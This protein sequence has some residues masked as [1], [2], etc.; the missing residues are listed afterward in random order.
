MDNDKI[1]EFVQ[2]QIRRNLTNLF[3][4][5]LLI[6]ED[7]NLTDSEYQKF[8]KRI[9]DDSNNKLREIEETFDNLNISFKG[10]NENIKDE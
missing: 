5:F 1:K 10:K 9:L 3:K 6:L 2:F 8:R 7:C 4:N